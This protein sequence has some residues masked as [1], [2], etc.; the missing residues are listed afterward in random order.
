[1]ALITSFLS[2]L[3][4]YF[5]LSLVSFLIIKIGRYIIYGRKINLRAEYPY[6]HAYL[7]N[8]F[9]VRTFYYLSLSKFKA[10]EFHLL[11]GSLAE[12]NALYH[13]QTA[14]VLLPLELFALQFGY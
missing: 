12:Y 14:Y 3:I 5:S 9:S 11:R 8:V 2:P 6:L 13:H 10:P 7:I 4:A 1:M